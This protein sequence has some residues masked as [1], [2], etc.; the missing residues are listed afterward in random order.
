MLLFDKGLPLDI[1][2]STKLTVDNKTRGPRWSWIAHLNFLDDHNQF[3]FVAFREKFTRISVCLYS[4][5][6]PHSLM[7]CLF[8]D[9]NFANN[10]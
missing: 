10:F 9:Q 3:F 8:T 7:P 1:F 5:S 4:A 6:S 2:D